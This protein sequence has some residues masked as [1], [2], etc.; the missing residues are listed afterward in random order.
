M[1]TYISNARKIYQ[2]INAQIIAYSIRKSTGK[3]Y[4]R[5]HVVDNN[6]NL[7]EPIELSRSQLDSNISVLMDY[8]NIKFLT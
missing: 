8:I 1:E 6:N 5:L 2:A 7:S 3:T 4:V